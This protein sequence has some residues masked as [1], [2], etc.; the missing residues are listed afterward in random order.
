M[1][2]KKDHYGKKRW[3][4]T[5]GLWRIKGWDGYGDDPGLSAF[6]EGDGDANA[7]WIYETS[8]PGRFKATEE[9]WRGRL[10]S[11][12]GSKADILRILAG[13]AKPGRG[14]S[15][16]APSKS[17]RSAANYFNMSKGELRHLVIAG[18]AGAKKELKRRGRD[19]KGRK[20]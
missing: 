17:R 9:G 18:D 5:V 19:G 8:T 12:Q 15:K 16:A 14:R 13:E 2:K 11:H 20:L 3:P 10:T 4:A 7:F 6:Y 1:A